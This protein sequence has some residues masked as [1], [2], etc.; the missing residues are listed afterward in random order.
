MFQ[1]RTLTRG[2]SVRAIVTFLAGLFGC[3]ALGEETSWYAQDF[4]AAFSRRIVEISGTR[5][6]EYYSGFAISYTEYPDG[7][8][9]VEFSLSPARGPHLN[10]TYTDEDNDGHVDLMYGNTAS[11]EAMLP[12]SPTSCRFI[13]VGPEIIPV[14]KG[15][16]WA[17]APIGMDGIM[18]RR[19]NGSWV[20]SGTISQNVLEAR[21]RQIAA[22]VKSAIG[23]P[24]ALEEAQGDTNFNQAQSGNVQ[25]ERSG[26][27][28]SAIATPAPIDGASNQ[29]RFSRADPEIPWSIERRR[30]VD[31]LQVV[32]LRRENAKLQLA[33]SADGKVLKLRI[34]DELSLTAWYPQRASQ[35]AIRYEVTIRDRLYDDLDGDGIIDLVSGANAELST[36]RVGRMLVSNCSVD[37]DRR[38]AKTTTVPSVSYV[39]NDGDWIEN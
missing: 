7:S 20:K 5:L 32:T 19:S 17:K 22:S 15:R 39:F 30:D 16:A 33:C 36:I 18:Y 27:T 37:R 34:G 25:R 28:E 1:V 13:F 35:T 11:E 8:R 3:V 24:N 29:W 2:R 38:T 21:R 31:G 26:T 23:S 9:G 12:L 6:R 4:S 14:Q 10:V